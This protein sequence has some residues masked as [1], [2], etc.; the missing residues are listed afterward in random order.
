MKLDKLPERVE[1]AESPLARG[2]RIE[3]V[4]ECDVEVGDGSPLARGA[5][6]ET[7]G[8]G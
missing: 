7:D 4:G 5:R 2:A 6:I 1:V 8:R 3:T